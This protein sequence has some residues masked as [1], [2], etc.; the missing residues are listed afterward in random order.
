MML[1][2]DACTAVA[3]CMLC[4]RLGA[5]LLCAWLQNNILKAATAACVL[6]S[7]MAA[8]PVP[9]LAVTYTVYSKIAMVLFILAWL[10]FSHCCKHT[11]LRNPQLPVAGYIMPTAC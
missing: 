10:I 5:Y 1:K 7:L 8:N 3:A 2:S 6:A 9:T 4:G 11:A